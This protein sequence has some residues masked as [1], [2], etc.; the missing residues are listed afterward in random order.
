MTTLAI[1]YS[2]KG[3][4][5][6][7]LYNPQRSMSEKQW[8]SFESRRCREAR[9]PSAHGTCSVTT[10]CTGQLVLGTSATSLVSS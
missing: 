3:T 6:W 4:R 8:L 7:W 10:P 9:A 2:R 5:C 1:G